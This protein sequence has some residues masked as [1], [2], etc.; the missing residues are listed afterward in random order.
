MLDQ[1]LIGG[2]A[3][4]LTII[5]QVVVMKSLVLFYRVRKEWLNSG[6]RAFRTT[7]TMIGSVLWL[8]LGVVI[9]TWV[10]AFILI[11]IGQFATWEPAVY[12]ALASFTTVGYGDVVL[13]EQ[14]R[15]LGVLSSVN[16]MIIFG[17]NT[18]ILID[19]IIKTW[20]DPD[21]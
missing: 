17:L 3:I 18:A 21:K 14:W 15:I 4:T 10:W 12:F 11:V 9:S 7:I 8:V 16:G 2:F 20:D 6:R 1:L 13:T 19:L 5:I